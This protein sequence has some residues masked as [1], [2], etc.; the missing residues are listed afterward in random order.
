MWVASRSYINSNSDQNPYII[1]SLE[2]LLSLNIEEL[3]SKKQVEMT[4][5][6]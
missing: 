1:T 6:F 3:Y 4:L 5:L 2:T